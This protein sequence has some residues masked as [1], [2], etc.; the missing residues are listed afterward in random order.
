MRVLAGTA[1]DPVTGRRHHPDGCGLTLSPERLLACVNPAAEI[2]VR[3][4]D[5]HRN[6]DKRHPEP[7]QRP[8]P[9][10]SVDA[11]PRNAMGKVHKHLLKAEA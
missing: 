9:V 5:L 3:E 6:S 4:V 7:E 11:L 1:F 2:R 8:R 10:R